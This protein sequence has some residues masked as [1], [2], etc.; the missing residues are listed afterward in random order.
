MF[1]QVNEMKYPSAR[2]IK[3]ITIFNS[4]VLKNKLL[5]R[6][7]YDFLFGTAVFK[8]FRGQENKND[9]HTLKLSEN[10]R[11]KFGSIVL[12]R[13]LKLLSLF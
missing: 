2:F 7:I 3:L 8:K 11:A 1:E 12:K 13:I 10:S 6:T 4:N 9:N 5:L